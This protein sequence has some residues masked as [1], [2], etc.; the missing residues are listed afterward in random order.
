MTATWNMED[1]V[2]GKGGLRVVARFRDRSAADAARL[3]VDGLLAQ[4]K[5]EVRALLEER[6]GVAESRDLSRIYARVGLRNDV[7]W[8]QEIDLTVCDRDLTWH[9]PTGA[10]AEDAES[11]LWSLGA[12]EIAIDEGDSRAPWHDA[13]HPMALPLPDEEA[14]PQ[15]LD[16]EEIQSPLPSY[17][18]IL[19]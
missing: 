18:R 7:G 6:G 3:T 12:A 13:P 14:A 4:A 2:R 17:K 11:L 9:L 8:E 10:H 15:G 16:D 19:H 5:A 1:R